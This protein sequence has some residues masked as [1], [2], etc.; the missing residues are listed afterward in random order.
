NWAQGDVE[1]QFAAGNAAMM[2]NGSWQIPNLA[3]D[4]PDL[5]YQIISLPT[6]GTNASCM[7][8][9]NIGITTSC[10]NMEAAWDFLTYATSKEISI[11]FNS[12]IGTISP[13]SDVTA[14]EQYPENDAMQVFAQQMAYAIAR[15]PSPKWSEISENIQIAIQAVLID[16][17]TPAQAGSTAPKK[18]GEINAT[19][20]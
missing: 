12:S 14:E 3:T 2:L 20:K 6:D 17:E 18:I 9:E 8:G 4:A 5:K 15:G 7:G 10:D 16:A 19:L 11:A 1:K 13:R